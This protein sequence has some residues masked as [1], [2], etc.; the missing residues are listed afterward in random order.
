[1]PSGL[2]CPGSVFSWCF[3]PFWTDFLAVRFWE[4][5]DGG[6]LLILSCQS[7]KIMNIYTKENVCLVPSTLFTLW[8]LLCS[9]WLKLGNSVSQTPLYA[10]LLMSLV[11]RTW[12]WNTWNWNRNHF[13]HIHLSHVTAVGQTKTSLGE[14]CQHMEFE[15]TVPL[16]CEWWFNVTCI[17]DSLLLEI[18]SGLN[19][20]WI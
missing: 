2:F 19:I 11:L 12:N 18:L 9:G 20:W 1:M 3:S 4:F 16:N 5:G 13:L 10:D 14:E 7:V 15:W 17:Y 8:P 6:L